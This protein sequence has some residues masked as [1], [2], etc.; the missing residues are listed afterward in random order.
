VTVG[1]GL[2]VELPTERTDWLPLGL[3]TL[4]KEIRGL[5]AAAIRGDVEE[6][7]TTDAIGAIESEGTITIE[8]RAIPVAT[9]YGG[10]R[11]RGKR[12]KRHYDYQP[13]V[14]SQ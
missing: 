2:E 6:T 14:P 5:C 10:H 11:R 3:D 9:H 13:Y 4:E 8:G 7:V 1:E 12:R